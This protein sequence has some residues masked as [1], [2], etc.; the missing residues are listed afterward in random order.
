MRATIRFR[1]GRVE[2]PMCVAAKPAQSSRM[3]TVGD[4]HTVHEVEDMGVSRRSPGRACAANPY[5]RVAALKPL[6]EPLPRLA[7]RRDPPPKHET[8]NRSHL[9]TASVTRRGRHEV[10]DSE[11]GRQDRKRPVSQPYCKHKKPET[12]HRP[13][14]PWA[15][16][17]RRQILEGSLP[18]DCK[19]HTR[20]L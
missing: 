13:Y 12:G 18:S 17:E 6:V 7:D 2:S 4:M 1:T 5:L 8:R 9:R 10:R 19:Q 16:T 15:W 11:P 3:H 20:I 14:P